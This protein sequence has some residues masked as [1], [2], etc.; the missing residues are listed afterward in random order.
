MSRNRSNR[1]THIPRFSSS[2]EARRAP[3]D[4]GADAPQAHELQFYIPATGPPSRP[5]RTLKHNDTFA[6]F[7]SH[8]DIGATAGGPDGLFDHDTRYLSHLELLIEGA[9]P[10]LLDS[11][12]R[13]DNL[14]FYVDL[15]N[16][17]IFRDE[18]IALLKELR[19]CLAH[20][21][22]QGRLAARAAGNLQSERRAAPAGS[23]DRLRQ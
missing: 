18:T 9:Q 12:I 20:A 4:A 22:S 23:V 16:P 5:R 6:V 21:V 2:D 7:D 15:T 19:L 10:L 8:G 11:A 17:D 13:D 3:P 14:S 1:T